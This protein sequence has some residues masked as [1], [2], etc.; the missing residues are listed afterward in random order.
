VTASPSELRM[1]HSFSQL[2]AT[3]QQLGDNYGARLRGTVTAPVTGSSTFFISSDDSGELWFSETPTGFD[4]NSLLGTRLGP[5]STSG[6][7]TIPSA[8]AP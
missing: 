4:K 7:N 2:L 6:G 8:A 1:P 3:A 5:T